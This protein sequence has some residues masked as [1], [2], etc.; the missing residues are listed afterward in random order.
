MFYTLKSK[1]LFTFSLLLVVPFITMVVILSEQSKSSVE[2]IITSSSAQTLEQY[3]GYVDM[4]SKQIED[5]AFQVLGNE[6]SQQWIESRSGTNRQLSQNERYALNARVKDY[7]A[8]IALS[9]SNIAS[10]SLHDSQGFVVGIDSVYEHVQYE[11]DDWYRLVKENGP[12]WVGSHIDP[13]QPRHLY[14]E[15]VISLVFPLVELKT[16]TIQ[17]AIKVNVYSSMIQQPLAK[18]GG[19]EWSTVRLVTPS[20]DTVTDLSGTA[21]E[22]LEH[23]SQFTA[24]VK[25]NESKGVVQLE[26]NDGTVRYWFYRKLT[27]KDWILIGEI[28]EKELFHDIHATRRT[29]LAIGGGVLLLTIVAVYWISSGMTRP[30]S[31][32]SKAMRKLEMGDFHAA[33]KLD[34]RG[35]GEAGYVLHAFARMAGRLQRL[36]RDEFTLKLRKQDAEYKALLMQVNPH[37]LY[38]TLE[39]IGGL[40][41][42][43]KTEQLMDVT[44]SLGQMLRHSLKLDTDIVT[45]SEDM[46]HVRYYAKIMECRFED[47]IKF[48][49]EEDASLQRVRIIKFILQPLVENAV[50]YRREDEVP[51]VV[52]ITVKRDKDSIIFIVEDNGK[53]MSAEQVHEIE[54]DARSEDA[55]SVLGSAGRRI[56]LRNVLARCRLYYGDLFKVQI[57]SDLGKGTTICLRLPISEGIDD[58][59][60]AAGR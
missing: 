22:L 43:N 30:L 36:I 35:K 27:I 45:V 4:L 44:E 20:G 46:K 24:L 29:M 33:E 53:G 39:I 51:A 54:S 6:L 17:G 32:L 7:I 59:Q 25:D 15:P 21:E 42:Q 18:I 37:F 41:A 13:Y 47:E 12:S 58:V 1:M 34:I 2:Q 10:I 50:K 60:S 49:I 28:T 11:S 23:R 31:H 48:E 19:N 5:I 26:G 55:A 56:G 14:R 3:A 16:L 40:A 52:R 57:R 38:N 8:Q 9:H